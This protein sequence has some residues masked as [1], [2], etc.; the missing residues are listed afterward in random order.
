MEIKFR[1]KIMFA[2]VGILFVSFI[3]VLIRATTSMV[4]VNKFHKV[5]TFTEAILGDNK[6][7]ANP[8]KKKKLM[9]K[10]ID[11]QGLY[12]FDDSGSSNSM[13]AKA[14][15]NKESKLTTLVKS[16]N[17]RE[18]N[19]DSWT[20]K[21]FF[22][23]I[24]LVQYANSYKEF[25]GWNMASLNA[26]NGVIEL[27]DKQLVV[28][29]KHIDVSDK[30]NAFAEL[31]R[32]CEAQNVPF[33]MVL[34]PSKISRADSDYSGKRDFS[35]QNGDAFIQGLRDNGV[36]HIDLRDN[37]D[38]EHLSQHELF[39]KTDHHWKPETARWAAKHI[40]LYLNQSSDFHSDLNLLSPEWYTEINYPSYFLGSRGKK[41]TL[42]RA[43]PDDFSLIYPSF[44]TD[45]HIEV[46]SLGIT[47]DGDFS[48]LYNMEELDPDKDLYQ[49]NPYAAYAYGDKPL[50][51]VI[52]K[53]LNDK[54]ILFIHDSFGDAV[55]PF[56][57]LGARQ[58]DTLDLRHFDGSL[59]TFINK[60]KPDVVILLYYIEELNNKLDLSTHK[61][62]F[63]FK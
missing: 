37:I 45:F 14:I 46:P 8:W 12:P 33:L 48:I 13:D 2:C 20:N 19:V 41:I 58:L 35:N 63:N 54:K 39:Y 15:S 60:E 57:A 29:Q 4:M 6:A 26:Y 3:M 47:K 52:N 22:H 61:N 49:R 31:A 34:A 28:F 62:V 43:K 36:E 18:Q 40:L 11:W 10:R 9:V 27:P 16:I 50:V 59:R 24:S 32:F 42:S 1:H 44:S 7:L 21:K 55:T 5:N 38:K 23:Y 30:I 25:I 56:L 51:R 53:S 17:T